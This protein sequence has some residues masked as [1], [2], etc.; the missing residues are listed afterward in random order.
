MIYKTTGACPDEIEIEVENDILI[1]CFFSNGCMINPKSPAR[2]VVGK[3]VDEIIRIFE[4]DQCGDRG[5]SCL[6]QLA[7]ALILMKKQL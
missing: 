2:S 6:D 7:K 3:N 1:K 4:G 5:T